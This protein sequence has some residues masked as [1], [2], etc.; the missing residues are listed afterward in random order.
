MDGNT[1]WGVNGMFVMY[2][3][4]HWKTDLDPL[5][6]IHASYVLNCSKKKP[7]LLLP[8]SFGQEIRHFVQ[9]DNLFFIEFFLHGFHRTIQQNFWIILVIFQH[10]HIH[11]HQH[12]LNAKNM[13]YT[14]NTAQPKGIESFTRRTKHH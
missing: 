8:C 13:L 9:Q 1:D 14:I 4:A 7:F 11:C 3:C 5:K 10:G 12:H 6:I 2:W